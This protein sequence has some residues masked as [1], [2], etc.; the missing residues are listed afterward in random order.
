M[1]ADLAIDAERRLRG[2]CCL[3]CDHFAGGHCWIDGAHGG[4]P[5]SEGMDSWCSQWLSLRSFERGALEE[6]A[7]DDSWD[8]D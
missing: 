2:E 3:N 8:D 4:P 7:D 6:L 1:S 5:S